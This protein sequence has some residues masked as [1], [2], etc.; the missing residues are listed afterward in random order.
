MKKTIRP[1]DSSVLCWQSDAADLGRLESPEAARMAFGL[2]VIHEFEQALLKLKSQD[3]VW[4]PVHSSIGQEAVAVGAISALRRSDKVASTHR[5]HHHFLAKALQYV[6]PETWNPIRD[7]WPQ[8]GQEVI[9]R[10]LAEIMGLEPGWCGG[11]G[12]SMHL[13]WAEAGFIGSNAI[14]A[15]GI[16]LATG[17]AFAEKYKKSGNVVLCFFGDGAINQ[18]AFHEAC[19]LAGLWQL[20]I[21]YFVENNFY[22]VA[23]PVSQACAVDEL[24]VRAHAYNMDGHSVNGHDLPALCEVTRQAADSVRRTGRPALIEARCY[25]HYH[26]A[27]D[28]PGSAYGYRSKEEEGERKLLDPVAQFPAALLQAGVLSEP[29]LAGI[30]ELAHGCVERAVA[31]CTIPGEEPLKVRAELW[32]KPE[33]AGEGLRSDGSELAGLSYQE[34]EDFAEFTEMRFS[35]AIATVTGHWLERDENVFVL[36]EEVA[37]FGGG[38]YGATKKLAAQYPTRVLNTP[39]SEAGFVGLGLGAAMLGL[40]PVIEIMFPDFSLVAADQIFNQIAKAR[41]MYGGTTNLPLV[42]RTRVAIGCGYGGQHSMDPIGLYA[43]FPGWRIVAPSNAFDYIGL[44]NTAMRSLDPVMII[45]YHDIYTR[46][47]PVPAEDRDYLIPF[48]KARVIREGTDL[49]MITYGAMT[50]RCA[51]LLDRFAEEGIAPELIDLR[52]VD[53]LGIDWATISDSVRRT[54]SVIVVEEASAS[55]SLGP[56]LAARIQQLS[57]EHLEHPVTCLASLDV[58]NPVSR[59]LEEA[60][61]L[62][63]RTILERTLALVRGGRDKAQRRLHAASAQAGA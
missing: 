9:D 19:N 54:R 29:E 20:P 28:M 40:R 6:L 4:G 10:T 52:T 45:E 12:G 22:A 39:I 33:S 47:F 7:E 63:D 23:T 57:F 16:P 35:D 3:C 62:S 18:G 34:P 32:P 38:A 24:A 17:A 14:V 60:A 53:P 36:G 21:I 26:H 44:F 5:A 2:L 1:C 58:P 25:R 37:N 13:R 46:K 56:H 30:R 31:S 50:G 42:L 11:R 8:G 59:V 41:H 48:G 27:G 43:L 61:I 49:T 51:A 55:Q 15:G